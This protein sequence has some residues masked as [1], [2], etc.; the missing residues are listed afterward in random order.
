MDDIDTIIAGRIAA[1][2][3]E[4]MTAFQAALTTFKNDLTALTEKVHAGGQPGEL[5]L[6]EL[7]VNAPLTLQLTDV[8]LKVDGTSITVEKV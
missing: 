8:T 7:R 1:A 3:N 5:Q 4:A 6:A 2:V